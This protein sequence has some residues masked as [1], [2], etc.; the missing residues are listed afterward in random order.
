VRRSTNDASLATVIA[1]EV[2]HFLALQHVTNV[3]VSGTVYSDP[4]DDTEPGQGNL[5][6]NGSKL[7]A[8][9]GFAISRSALLQ[10]Q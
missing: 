2:S 9:Q 5:M 6:Q 1:H 7:T 3:G 8:D 4:L 10:T